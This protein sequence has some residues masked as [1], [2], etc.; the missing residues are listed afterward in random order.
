MSILKNALKEVDVVLVHKDQC[1]LDLFSYFT[2]SFEKR[3]DTYRNPQEFLNNVDQYPKHAKIIVGRTFYDDAQYGI[4]IAEQLHAL[5]FTHL[6]LIVM[7]GLPQKPLP[8]YLAVIE[9]LELNTLKGIFS[10]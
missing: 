3:V 2:T 4:Q 6:Y 5:G 1:L 10:N 7:L 9:N 8:D